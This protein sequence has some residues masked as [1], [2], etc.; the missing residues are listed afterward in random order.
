MNA[1]KQLRMS[2][3]DYY[4][5]KWRYRRGVEP[6]RLCLR[7]RHICC[8]CQIEYT[9]KTVADIVFI[10]FRSV[11]RLASYK[12]DW[13]GINEY[14]IN[15]D[16]ISMFFLPSLQSYKKTIIKIQTKKRKK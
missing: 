7:V 14:E 2:T 10:H 12:Y 9:D 15:I 13:K 4:N 8:V 6:F 16:S 5:T 11:I 1:S 3:I